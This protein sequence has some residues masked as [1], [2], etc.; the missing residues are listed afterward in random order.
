M[1]KIKII[2]LTVLLITG[3]LSF[4]FSQDVE[5]KLDEAKAAY[6]KENLDDTRFAL[7]E[8]LHELD[9]IVG[10]KILAIMPEEMGGLQFNSG[11][12][13]VTGNSSGAGGLYVN[14]DYGSAESQKYAEILIVSDSPMLASINSILSMPLIGAMSGDSGQKRIKIDGYK[15]LMQRNDDDGENVSYDIQIPFGGS[16]LTF[17]CTGFD[18]ESDVLKMVNTIPVSK[19]DSLTR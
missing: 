3:L 2:S 8:A 7:E 19:I 12:D 17:N 14:R 5:G 15:G 18:N 16:L 13:N 1:N 9:M 10:K 11:Q 6:K 4:S